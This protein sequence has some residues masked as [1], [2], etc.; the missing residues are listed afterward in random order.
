[1]FRSCVITARNLLR[2]SSD[3]SILP[4][5][6]IDELLMKEAPA[7]DQLTS[8]NEWA[9]KNV[10]DTKIQIATADNNFEEKKMQKSTR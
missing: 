2:F 6:T 1:M 10:G 5:L 3:S 4:S 8:L 7:S 9:Y